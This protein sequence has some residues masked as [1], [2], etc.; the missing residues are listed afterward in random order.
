MASNGSQVVT[1]GP[2]QKL[3]YIQRF[4][5]YW[6]EECSLVIFGTSYSK[7]AVFFW[8]NVLQVRR[9]PGPKLGFRGSL[10][11]NALLEINEVNRSFRWGCNS[12]LDPS[13][14]ISSSPIV[15]KGI[16]W[17]YGHSLLSHSAEGLLRLYGH[18]LLSYCVEGT[19]VTIW[20]LPPF[21]FCRRDYCD[22]MAI[23]SSPILQKGL[24]RLYGHCLLSHSAEVTIET[25]MAVASSPIVQKGTILT[26]WP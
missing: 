21:P 13:V 22:H 8:K 7:T 3:F 19:I 18:S 16:L 4:A 25:V 24:L 10:D 2:N 15:Q 1:T 20:P 9:P 17:P 23:A 5:L 6:V 11:P 12:I 26:I 14:A